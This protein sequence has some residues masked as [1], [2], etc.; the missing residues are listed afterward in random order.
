MSKQAPA[1]QLTERPPTDEFHALWLKRKWP[2]YY[3]AYAGERAGT[4]KGE[5]I[6]FPHKKLHACFALL[7]YGI[8][9]LDTLAKV[10]KLSR[11]SPVQIR[12][13]RTERRFSQV[14][15]R[16]V[17]ELADDYLLAIDRDADP[18]RDQE[19]S[20]LLKNFGSFGIACQN[21][22]LRRLFHDVLQVPGW[23]PPF[24]VENVKSFLQ[25][26]EAQKYKPP[27]APVFRHAGFSTWL[28][29]YSLFLALRHAQPKTEK[30][31]LEKL[32][33]WNHVN[34]QLLQQIVQSS[35]SS[36]RRGKPDEAIMQLEAVHVN[37]GTRIQLTTDRW[38]DNSRAPDEKSHRAIPGPTTKH[39]AAST[40]SRRTA[41]KK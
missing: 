27:A 36:I 1:P 32:E 3:A 4:P 17:W 29:C 7:S 26:S 25:A 16:L 41:P 24:F 9:A 20:A 34:N 37:L 22:V 14:F 11:V 6:P 10:A 33:H 28:L 2:E 8:P 40:K 12:V 39:K 5:L 31:T 35:I 13:W 23:V 21:A 38:A 15:H 19:P 18:K 30:H